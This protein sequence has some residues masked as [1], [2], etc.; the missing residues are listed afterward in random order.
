METDMT[1]SVKLCSNI[2]KTSSLVNFSTH[3]LKKS[4]KHD[5]SSQMVIQTQVMINLTLEA[6]LGLQTD[7]LT[8]A[9]TRFLNLRA[10]EIGPAANVCVFVLLENC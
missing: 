7:D 10:Q 3:N 2:F 9:N 5:S 6:L 8:T 1:T 4:N